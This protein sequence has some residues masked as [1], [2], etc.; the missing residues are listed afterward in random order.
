MRGA[1][2]TSAGDFSSPCALGG[3]QKR[4]FAH[5]AGVPRAARVAGVA[6]RRSSSACDAVDAVS[7]MIR[8]P[9]CASPPAMASGNN[10]MGGAARHPL[11]LYY[12]DQIYDRKLPPQG[13]ELVSV[14]T[15]TGN[16]AL[17]RA[18]FAFLA[19]HPSH[20]GSVRLHAAHRD[21]QGRVAS[22]YNPCGIAIDSN[23]VLYVAD[24]SNNC[25]RVVSRGGV[26]ATLSCHED[27]AALDA[28][29]GIAVHEDTSHLAEGSSG[30]GEASRDEP[31]LARE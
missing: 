6:P 27:E 26:V 17:E 12:L 11:W 8:A 20:R 24:Y 28:P 7:P 18:V 10:L 15:H 2:V 25:V 30:C 3:A 31:R 22:F 9:G 14:A 23:D 1:C 21:G 13:G 19:D 29:Y 4:T 5:F 16:G